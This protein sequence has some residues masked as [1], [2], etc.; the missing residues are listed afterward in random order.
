MDGLRAVG[1]GDRAEGRAPSNRRAF[2]AIAVGVVGVPAAYLGALAIATHPA[3]ATIGSRMTY[4]GDTMQHLAV[5]RWYLECLRDGRSPMRMP[6]L[7]YPVGAPLGLFS[8]LQLQSLIFGPLRLAGLG[9]VLCYK[10]VWLIGFLG[11]GLGTFALAYRVVRSRVAAALGGL[12]A[13]LSGPMML[14]GFGHTELIY[15]GTFPLFLLCWLRFVDR[16][17][18]LRMALAAASYL[19]VVMA[20]AYYAVLAVPT[21]IL[22]VVWQGWGAARRGGLSPWLRRVVP[23]FSGFAATAMA[24]AALLLFPQL[25]ASI[26][27]FAA[28]R[29]RGQFDLLKTPPWAYLTPT[30]LHPLGRRLL[31]W[32]PYESNGLVVAESGA[33][34]GVVTIGLLGYAAASRAG[35]RASR[36]WW[37]A[38]ALLVVLASGSNWTIGRVRVPLPC[39]WLWRIAPPFRFIRSPARFNLLAAVVAAVLASMGLKHLLDRFGSRGARFAIA[40][41]LGLIAVAD[42]RIVPFAFGGAAIPEM[43]GAYA[44]LRDRAPGAAIVEVPQFASSGSSLSAEATYWQSRHALKTTAGYSG[45]SNAP[46]DAL[47]VE[48]SPFRFEDLADP[49]FLDHP[50]SIR[51]GLVEGVDYLDYARLYLAAHELPYIVLF[52]RPED[53][54]EAPVH[55]EA[56]RRLLRGAAVF[57]DRRTVVYDRDRLGTPGRPVVLPTTGWDNASILRGRNGRAARPEAALALFNPGPVAAVRL[58]FEAIAYMSPRDVWLVH[59][60]ATVARWTVRPGAFQRFETPPLPLDGFGEFVLHSGPRTSARPGR[61]VLFVSTVAIDGVPEAAGSPGVA[62]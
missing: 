15:L 49:R 2:G 16:P 52:P 54:P 38:L 27:G 61:S 46:F 35:G 3:V 51:I 19:L 21:A 22:Y 53:V 10:L 33:Y 1:S 43:P 30:V 29:S 18:A 9:D 4:L 37:A 56:F 26:Q 47:M 41:I 58:K 25:W 50:E 6:G 34:L 12:L 20:A 31:P 48:A 5:M 7:Q 14:H 44:L 62:D 24:G 32:T 8:P 60:G 39:E 11:T 42:L 59:R 55:L 23:W 13:M 45:Q 40:A 57:E 28:P 36:F 17:G